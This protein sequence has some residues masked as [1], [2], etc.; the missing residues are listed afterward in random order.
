MDLSKALEIL[1]INPKE[2]GYEKITLHY[3]KKKYYKLALQYHPDKNSEKENSNIKFQQINEAYEYLRREISMFEKEDSPTMGTDPWAFF[4]RSKENQNENN[5]SSFMDSSSYTDYKTLLNLFIQ[6]ILKNHSSLITTIIQKIVSGYHSITLKMF[7]ELNKETCLQIYDFLSKY[8]NVLYLSNDILWKLRE[9]ILEK[10]KHD[11][12]YLLNPSIDDLLDCNVYKL[13]ID[14]VIYF[15][16]LWHIDCDILFDKVYPSTTSD[17]APDSDS[18]CSSDANSPFS[19]QEEKTDSTNPNTSEEEEEEEN[20]K[21][22]EKNEKTEKTEKREKNPISGEIIVRCIPELPENIWIDEND[23]V[24]VSLSIPLPWNE[25]KEA[26]F[27]FWEQKRYPFSLGKKTLEIP[28]NE[29]RMKKHQNYI[30]R[31]KGLM[32]MQ[33]NLDKELANIHDLNKRTDIRVEITF[34]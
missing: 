15:V 18:S 25:S 9:I 11:D 34:I 20:E 24:V 28:I 23:H 31:G 5:Y 13:T 33:N 7:E 30:F 27:S 21:A 17:D 4:S 10:C 19:T 12:V 2:L 16:P 1:E 6:G 22:N 29:L 8:K 14:G 32:K 26:W 3:L